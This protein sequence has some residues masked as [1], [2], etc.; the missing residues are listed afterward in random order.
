MGYGSSKFNLIDYLHSL[1]QT[2]RTSKYLRPQVVLMKLFYVKFSGYKRF[3]NSTELK[4][5]SKMTVLVGP[6]E[7]G[8]SSALAMLAHLSHSEPFSSRE[9]YKFQD[10][11]EA[12]IYAEFFL[13][14]EDHE[15]I[16][17]HVPQKYILRKRNDGSLIHSLEPK[18]ERPRSHRLRFEAALTKCIDSTFLAKDMSID[19]EQLEELKHDVKNIEFDSENIS[20]VSL[21]E[22]S[23][24]SSVLEGLE[25]SSPPKYISEMPDR[26]AAFIEIECAG[27][28]TDLA[29]EILEDRR[30][31][32]LEFTAKDRELETAYDMSLYGLD[33]SALQQDPCTALI[34]L[35][36]VS[37]FDLDLLDKNIDEGN[38]DRIATQFSNANTRLKN[39]FDSTWSQSDISIVLS[40]DKPNIQIMVNQREGEVSE[41]NMIDERSDGFRQYVALLAF[42]IKEDAQK[43]ILLIDEAELHL[44]YDAQADL[45]QTFTARDLASQ[46]IYT[47]HSAGCLPEDLGVG[48][49]LVV[50]VESGE[51][52]ATS[53]IEN[54]FWTN[55]KL[56]FSPIL[57]GMGA[58]TLAFFPTRRAVVTEGQTEM[59]LMPTIFRQVSQSDFNGF[60]IVPGLANSS[61]ENLP[62][63]N[64][65]GQE[66]SFLVDNDD[67][68][69]KYCKQLEKMG[70]PKERLFKICSSRSSIVTVEDWV[71]DECFTNAV[72]TYRNRYF[73]DKDAFDDKFFYGDGKA[74]KL[75]EYQKKIQVDI[76]KT[77]LA[78]I[79]LEVTHTDPGKAIFNQKHKT[80]INNLRTKLMSSFE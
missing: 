4:L 66:V 22:L 62:L 42:I 77:V 40:W 37:E 26:I 13:D 23:L 17:S 58:Q 67:A 3:L 68:G 46:V 20:A 80:R 71:S 64:S 57:Y 18:I 45:I 9:K 61:N 76:S 34:N 50:P 5:N 63:F 55:D 74:N 47:T 15:A 32:I 49:K 75:D 54:N 29:L 60:Q 72:E 31:K 1:I 43:P 52:I 35:C 59:L 39:I 56:G 69:E 38:P 19:E 41:Y 24:V 70:I 79:I 12:N 36:E 8:K 53:T 65:Q 48:V 10:N 11:V 6:N 21:K 73:R 30:P 7:A 33:N 27:N 78:Y 28:P 25:Q 16:G 44:H 2:S 51:H 14:G